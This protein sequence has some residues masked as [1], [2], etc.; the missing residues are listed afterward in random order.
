MKR[1]LALFPPFRW[2]ILVWNKL[3]P[4]N[5]EITMPTF[6]KSPTTLVILG[7]LLALV[8]ETISI[9]GL[10]IR[11]KLG[12]IHFTLFSVE[13]YKE[14]IARLELDAKNRKVAEAT[15]HDLQVAVN[16]Q[17]A[18]ISRGISE[19]INEL[20]DTTDQQ[21]K[22]A[23]KHYVYISPIN[24]CLRG[25]TAGVLGQQAGVSKA[26][27]TPQSGN[28]TNLAPDM[29]AIPAEDLKGYI[30][31]TDAL[32]RLREAM[33]EFIDSGIAVPWNYPIVPTPSI[34]VTQPDPVPTETPVV[35]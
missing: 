4:G 6:N 2:I 34:E 16:N 28:G 7:L 13:G 33:T 15:N 10:H 35:H 25:Q 32:D 17:P 21:L 1:I 30:G 31:N 3:I 5:R 19:K 20:P 27:S 14:K 8:F 12:F 22:E 26:D 29:V 18:V 24:Q 9:T 23:A 11:P